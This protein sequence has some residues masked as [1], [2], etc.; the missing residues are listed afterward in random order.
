MVGGTALDAVREQIEEARAILNAQTRRS[1]G[2]THRTAAL[3][4]QY[5]LGPPNLLPHRS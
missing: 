5:D 2:W 4:A 1:A 3:P